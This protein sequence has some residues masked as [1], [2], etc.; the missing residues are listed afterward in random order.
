MRRNPSGI[1]EKNVFFSRTMGTAV[2][3][4]IL[5]HYGAWM[6]RKQQSGRQAHM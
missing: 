1:L 6:G 4:V 3:A 5:A 2:T